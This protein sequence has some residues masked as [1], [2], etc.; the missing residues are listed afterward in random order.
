LRK[1]L[2]KMLVMARVGRR[3]LND[4]A[5]SLHIS[6]EGINQAS[7]ETTL[8]AVRDICL[9]QGQ[10]IAPTVPISLNAR[11]YSIRGFLG[12]NG[13]RWV[14]INGLFPLSRALEIVERIQQFFDQRASTLVDFGIKHSFI[15]ANEGPIWMVE[16]MFYWPDEIGP[17]HRRYLSPGKLERFTSQVANPQARRT[18]FKLRAEL[19]D[20]FFELGAVH[21]QI[22]KYYD[23]RGAVTPEVFDTLQA[24][25]TLLDPGNR[26][27]PGNFGWRANQ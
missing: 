26:L 23:F 11:P 18:V 3:V 19:R 1:R 25:K 7:A 15:V 22:G 21:T 8:A 10:E 6:A 27:N 16:P 2:A 17:L 20:L 13:E 4:V 12:L 9:V 14:P 5:W 24:M